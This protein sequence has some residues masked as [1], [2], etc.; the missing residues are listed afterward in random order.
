[1]DVGG[2]HHD[3]HEFT[4]DQTPE[5]NGISHDGIEDL[6]VARH[7]EGCQTGDGECQRHPKIDFLHECGE[8]HGA[9]LSFAV[10]IDVVH[11]IGARSARGLVF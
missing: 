3:E 2:E 4:D 1:M 10:L 11:V 6:F 7:V 9:A 5:E 8:G